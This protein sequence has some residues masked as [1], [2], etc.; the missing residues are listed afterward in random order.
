MIRVAIVDDNPEILS[1]LEKK[2][3][4]HY[5]DELVIKTI[6]STDDFYDEIEGGNGN[7]YDVVLM[8]IVMGDRTGIELANEYLVRHQRSKMIFITG[9]A[10]MSPE[11]FSSRP[12]GLVHKPIKDY[13]LFE[14][15]DRAIKLHGEDHGEYVRIETKSQ[16]YNIA[17]SEIRYVESK[18]HYLNIYTS[19]NMD[20]I[21]MK[22]S[23]LEKMVE[24]IKDSAFIRC[25]Q[26]FCVNAR[27]ISNFSNNSIVLTDGTV[28][29]VSRNKQTKAK[30]VFLDYIGRRV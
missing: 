12:V 16:I 5:G 10:E 6:S 8:D 26:S 29:P 25:H 15:I 17:I 21:N 19:N 4:Q 20:S 9:H 14:T 30:E 3:Q 11:I 24:G 27:Y 22:L 1:F 7:D 18:G 2:I 23:D 13:K 28:I